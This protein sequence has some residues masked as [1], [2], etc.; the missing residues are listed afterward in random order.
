MLRKVG[1]ITFSLLILVGNSKAQTVTS[2]G[3]TG[4][5]GNVPYI[6]AASS[7]S[8]TLGSSPISIAGGNVG[9]STATND[10]LLNVGNS[11]VGN[12]LHSIVGGGYAGLFENVYA[13]YG[14]GG[15]LLWVKSVNQAAG[16]YHF[17]VQGNNNPEFVVEGNGSVGIGTS[18]PA[19]PL[20]IASGTVSAGSQIYNALTVQ[21]SGGSAYGANGSSIF[22]SSATNYVSPATNSNIQ[23]TAGLWSSLDTGGSGAVNYGGSL[24][25]GST[26]QGNASPVERMRINYLGNVGIG[27][28]A[29]A[30]NLDVAGVARA[31]SGIIY[32]D[33]NKQTV[34]WTGVLC[35]GDYAEAVKTK[36]ELKNYGPGDVL[37]IASGKESDVEKASTPYSTTVAGI[38]ATKP[39]VIGRRQSLGR[40]TDDLPMAMV[41]IVPA[42]VSAENG[43]IQKGDL[44]VTASTPG[45]AMKGT[46][47]SRM[48]GAVIGKAMGE[49]D[50]GSGEIEVLV[51]L[52]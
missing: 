41:G 26:P 45:Y 19:A 47:R 17:Y 35:G 5:V 11:N 4:T 3:T 6:S 48:L 51:T 34:A 15:I 52:Q 31:Q 49:L 9:I 30:Y 12:S 1:I 50:S 43:P 40:D 28:A 2:S 18:T 32:P 21:P 7:T 23:P 14:T 16:S 38:Y 37:V 24:V 13:G 33:G 39:G 8:T 22:L 25:L 10:S 27:T 46:D 42:K 44:L 36:G 29:P 20:N